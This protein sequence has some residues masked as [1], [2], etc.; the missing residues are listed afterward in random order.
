L[1]A[2]FDVATGALRWSRVMG[3]VG[4]DSAH[5]IATHGD[6]SVAVAGRVG[7][8]AT[9]GGVALVPAG[10]SDVWAGRFD[11][12]TGAT[13]WVTRIGGENWDSLRTL[14][15]SADGRTWLGFDSASKAIEGVTMDPHGEDA[16][17]AELD[18]DGR[19]R[20]LLSWG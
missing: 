1:M 16:V 20:R 5:A 13:R 3:G 4:A 15:V 9:I 18:A 17:I 6:G 7:R 19:L 10:S 2:G 14:A 11:A 8:D 12:R